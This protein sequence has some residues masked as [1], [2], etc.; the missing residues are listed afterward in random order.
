MVCSTAISPVDLI[1]VR[2]QINQEVGQNKMTALTVIRDVIKT[3]GL[4]GFYR[5]YLS[6]LSREATAMGVYFGSYEFFKRKARREDGTIPVG[7]MLLS[8]GTAGILTWVCN[9]PIDV[10]KTQLQSSTNHSSIAGAAKHIYKTEGLR[11]F[12]RGVIPCVA[13]A[14]PVN[15]TVFGVYEFVAEILNERVNRAA[16]DE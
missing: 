6:V 7:L 3:E 1:K 15:A 2:L 10:I 8:G 16:A 4:R 9:Y 5:G 12:Y 13:R 14:F 11:G